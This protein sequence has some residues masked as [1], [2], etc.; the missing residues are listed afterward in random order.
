MIE[1]KLK[2]TLDC[3]LDTTSKSP[4]WL[5][6][7]WTVGTIVIDKKDREDTVLIFCLLTVVTILDFVSF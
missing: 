7:S 4:L 5:I 3:T 2:Q 1:Y 6:S